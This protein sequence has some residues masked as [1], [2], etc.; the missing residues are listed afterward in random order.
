MISKKLGREYTHHLFLIL[1]SLII[2]VALGVLTCYQYIDL[3]LIFENNDIHINILTVSSMIA[4]FLFSGLSILMALNK[5]E[6][7]E[8]LKTAGRDGEVYNSYKYGIL[9]SLFSIILSTISFLTFQKNQ[10]LLFLEVYSLILGILYFGFTIHQLFIII[11]D[12]N[13]RK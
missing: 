7:M 12:F 1:Y 2:L 11:S 13:N 10:L 3:N 6:T 5:S 9:A 4:G 8:I